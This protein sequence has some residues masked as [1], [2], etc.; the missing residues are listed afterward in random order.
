MGDA[1]VG[2]PKV[3]EM[4]ANHGC[5]MAIGVRFERRP[6]RSVASQFLEQAHLVR[7]VLKMDTRLCPMTRPIIQGLSSSCICASIR[8]RGTRL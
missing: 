6:E 5:A 7:E 1:Q 4:A 2:V 8:T 3:D